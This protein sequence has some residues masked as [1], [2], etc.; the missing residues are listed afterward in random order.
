MGWLKKIK[1]DG[2]SLP[3]ISPAR[4]RL[5]KPFG[6]LASQTWSG[7]SMNTFTRHYR[8]KIFMLILDSHFMNSAITSMKSPS[9]SN[10]RQ[11]AR[12]FR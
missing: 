10:A 12:S 11:A 9:G 3:L 1:Q 6:S 4:A 5:Y 8:V 7:T 2:L